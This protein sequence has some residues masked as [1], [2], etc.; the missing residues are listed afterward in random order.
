MNYIDKM[1]EEKRNDIIN[2]GIIDDFLKNIAAKRA[3][4][5]KRTSVIDSSLI[6]ILKSIK[7]NIGNGIGL[8]SYGLFRTID[9]KDF[10]K[11]KSNTWRCYFGPVDTNNELN[12]LS[13]KISLEVEARI[14]LRNLIEANAKGEKINFEYY[15]SLIYNSVKSKLSESRF[16]IN[17]I[18]KYWKAVMIYVESGYDTE[19]EENI[20]KISSKQGFNNINVVFDLDETNKQ[21]IVS[22]TMI[23]D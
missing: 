2:E 19:L 7:S 13:K 9:D 21:L 12:E 6:I 14:N 22:V 16:F 20:T 1:I 15:R 4:K 18:K 23:E 8:E 5:N 11:G 3:I 17:E 10:I